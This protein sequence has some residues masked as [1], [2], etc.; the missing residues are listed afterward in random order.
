MNVF[1]IFATHI[2]QIIK[3]QTLSSFD[4]VS[5]YSA[6]A[7][8][9][10]V[11]HTEDDAYTYINTIFNTLYSYL[12][13][14]E[15]NSDTSS[16][17][18][19]LLEFPFTRYDICKVL[20]INKYSELQTLLPYPLRHSNQRKI[21][22][23]LSET[24]FILS[25][26]TELLL[27]SQCNC[28]LATEITSEFFDMASIVLEAISVAG[29][30]RTLMLLPT[31]ISFY[32]R[33]VNVVEHEQLFH[34]IFK[35][36]KQLRGLSA[37]V[38]L[39]SSIEIATIASQ[40]SYHQTSYFFEYALSIFE[41]HKLLDSSLLKSLLSSLASTKLEDYDNEMFIN[42]AVK[43]IAT[44]P[45]ANERSKLYCDASLALYNEQCKNSKLSYTFE[46]NLYLF[47]S[48]LNVAI[49][50]YIKGNPDVTSSYVNEL[51]KFVRQ[52]MEQQEFPTIQKFFDETILNVTTRNEPALKE[53]QL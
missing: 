28:F 38:A 13:Q 36:L 1:Q 52:G 48:I 50:Q 34:Q 4:F 23:K 37:S 39:T 47:V 40:V 31:V 43:F 9:S 25:N 41:D 45:N 26:K 42:A 44:L 7:D 53:L 2:T 8:L 17:L 5:I 46:Q 3:T 19:E 12:D 20:S 32:L 35:L 18:A 14:K 49:V 30:R 51:A 24:Q 33:A 16:K 6:L 11:W 15:L 29:N 21:V 10:I 27:C 22:E